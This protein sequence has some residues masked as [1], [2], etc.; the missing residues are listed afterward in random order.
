M[1]DANNITI[2][3]AYWNADGTKM[4]N[5]II[6][7]LEKYNIDIM[8]LGKTHL[9]NCNNFTIQN[10]CSCRNNRIHQMGG[11][12]TISVKNNTEHLLCTGETE[13]T[14]I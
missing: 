9:R 1:T 11:G 3:I 7:F 6:H 13:N 5:H 2:K 14:L 4:K 8:L 12:T 10:Y